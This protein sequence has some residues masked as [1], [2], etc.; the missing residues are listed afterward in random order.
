[1]FV[2]DPENLPTDPNSVEILKNWGNS[3]YCGI[4]VQHIVIGDLLD[5]D[6]ATGRNNTI[7]AP[8]TKATG[9]YVDSQ[10]QTVLEYVQTT[11]A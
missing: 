1:L 2:Y 11:F 9:D 10:C 4:S 5:N 8:S 7:N 3:Q 6:I